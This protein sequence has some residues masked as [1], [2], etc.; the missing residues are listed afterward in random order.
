MAATPLT[1]VEEG[2]EEVF[3]NQRWMVGVWAEPWLC[4]PTFSDW[5]PWSNAQGDPLSPPLP[6]PPAFDG[7]GGWRIVKGPATDAEGWQYA[8]KFERLA[9]S[10]EGGRACKRGSDSVRSRLWRR[11]ASYAE[12]D[13]GESLALCERR[14][15]P[16]LRRTALNCAFPLRCLLP[17]SRPMRL[18]PCYRF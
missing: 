8:R 9:H 1:A 15:L 16:R 14:A 12:S 6:R 5:A 10:R 17:A 13:E 7:D 18:A 11:R 3:Q 2:C 4:R